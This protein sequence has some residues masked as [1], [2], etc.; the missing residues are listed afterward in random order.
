MLYSICKETEKKGNMD[1]Q[2]IFFCRKCGALDYAQGRCP[3]CGNAEIDGADMDFLRFGSSAVRSP[4]MP[5][6]LSNS[7][8]IEKNG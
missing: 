2:K 3:K 6:L 4:A 8:V 1:Q 7:S 5:I